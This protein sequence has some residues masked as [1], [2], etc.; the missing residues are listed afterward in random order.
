MKIL[1]SGGTGK[2][3]KHFIRLN[4]E[5]NIYAP[6]HHKMDVS[7]FITV[8]REIESFEPDIFLHAGAFTRPTSRHE[9]N[10]ETGIESNIIGTANVVLAC[11]EKNI[12]LIYISTDYVYPGTSGNYKETDPLL[13]FNNYAWSKLGGEC[14][15]QMYKNSLILRICMNNRPFPHKKALADVK[16]SLIYDDEAAEITHK[17]LYEYGVINIGGK[18]QSIYEF[19]KEE[20]PDIEKIYLK[21]IKDVKMPK[22]STLNLDKMKKLLAKLWN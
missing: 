19:A 2:F 15:V 8:A 21:D 6:S 11:M 17:L 7:D 22:D 1:I 14:A 18:S 10:P 4:K 3:A 5:H 12:K 9:T 16:K 13:P 20:H